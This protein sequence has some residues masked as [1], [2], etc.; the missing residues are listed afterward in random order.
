M[1]FTPKWIRLIVAITLILGLVLNHQGCGNT[2]L[3]IAPGNGSGYEGVTP[4]TG[5]DGHQP[6]MIQ[7]TAYFV[8]YGICDGKTDRVAV[9]SRANGKY[10]LLRSNCM[11]LDQ[12]L[13]LNGEQVQVDPSI[14]N[15]L[16]YNG[17]EFQ[18]E[19]YD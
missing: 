8:Y 10:H 1:S 6:V 5:V 19:S 16:I 14:P 9:I 17:Q 12:P 4:D 2:S 11:D 18:K 7:L 15:I 13:L 3:L